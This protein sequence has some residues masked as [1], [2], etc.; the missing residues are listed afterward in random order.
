MVSMK[1]LVFGLTLAVCSAAWARMDFVTGGTFDLPGT[2]VARPY[3]GETAGV[4]LLAGGANF[5]D[6]PLVEGG[7]KVYHDS[8]LLC[9]PSSE[10]L[11]WR[12]VG[13]LPVPRG[14]GASAT[15]A[16]GVLCVGGKVGVHGEVATNDCFLMRWDGRAVQYEQL[17][18]LPAPVVMPGLAVHGDT[19]WCTVSNAIW[20][21]DLSAGTAW[22]RD[23]EIG[24]SEQPVLVYQKDRLHYFKGYGKPGEVLEEH[25]GRTVIGASAV[26]MGDQ[27]ILF[28]GG[29]NAEVWRARLGPDRPIA[30]YRIS[31]KIL[32]YHIV[33]D[34]WFELPGGWARCG[35]AAVKLADGRILLAGGELKPGVRSPLSTIGAFRRPAAY[36]WINVSVIVVYLLGMALMGVYFMRRNK[37]SD[38]YFRA[39]GKL[40][41]WV[42]SLS[43]YATMFSSITFI[44]VPAMSFS[45]DMRYFAISFGILILAPVVVRWYL[46]FFRRLN[47]TSAYE[48]L[49]VRFNLPCRLF[50]SAAFTLFM[51][52]RTGI[53]AYL[54]ALAV[55]AVTGIDI[56]TAIVSVT[57]I[58]IVYCTVGGVEAVIW[59]DFVQSVIL[60]A[61]TL[62]IVAWLICG[63]DGGFAG[64]LKMGTD[65][66][67]F[68]AFDFAFDWSK[69]CFWV[70]FISGVVANLASYTSDQCVVQRYMTT[71]DEKGAGRS[72]MLNGVLSFVN[73]FVF[74]TMGVA[75]WTFY[76]SHPGALAAG[77]K[78]DA[79]LPVFIAQQLPLG[80]S[81]LVFAAIAAATMSTLSS[82]LNSAAS[83]ITTDFY[84]RLFCG[85]AR[86]PE[87]AERGKLMCGRVSTLAVGL[88]GGAFALVLANADVGNIYDQFQRFLGIL[89]GG[90][91]CL[92]FMGVFMKRIDGFAAT[93]GLVA[94]YVVCF[95]LDLAPWSGKPHMLFYGF[96]GMVACLAVSCLCSL[97]RRENR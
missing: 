69:P 26:A 24:P 47:L 52:A 11:S 23:R 90:L 40:P 12:D 29:A 91:G 35:A 68:R 36:S 83:A 95:G 60:I 10:K 67:K 65:A 64:F 55:S 76:Q 74:F 66:G 6:R 44:S 46:P 25:L 85:R 41:W 84:E 38:D 8:I 93:C 79:V 4:V 97:V 33:T 20:K 48:Y 5:P 80:A 72:I 57:L 87:A 50:A 49:E 56:N 34:S 21:L 70:V 39:G 45:G 59:S 63:T 19:A 88:L 14:E 73:C 1:K 7:R 94:N 16:R 32:V 78:P 9:E 42:V 15:T 54:P 62:L 75:L 22:E 2:G 13:R 17:P 89:T 27:H 18:F 81:G 30:D 51:V 3:A 96:L 82:N 92:F 61:S 37:S 28:F 43:I 77:T 31:D 53:V 71:P 58:T 86:S